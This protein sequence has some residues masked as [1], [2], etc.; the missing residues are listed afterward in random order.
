MRSTTWSISAAEH[1]CEETSREASKASRTELLAG[2][3]AREGERERE[4]SKRARRA[5]ERE[6]ER[7]RESTRGVRVRVSI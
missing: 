3:R 2:N 5:R 1:R 6:S 7:A 4:K